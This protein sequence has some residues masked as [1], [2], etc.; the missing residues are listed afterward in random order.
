[1]L[2]TPYLLLFFF[3]S[4]YSIPALVAFLFISRET[5][6][7][8]INLRKQYLANGLHMSYSKRATHPVKLNRVLSV[9]R[10]MRLIGITSI[11]SPRR[12]TYCRRLGYDTGLRTLLIVSRVFLLPETPFFE[13]SRK[14]PIQ[15]GKAVGELP[16]HCRSGNHQQTN[17]Q[18]LQVALY[19]GSY[20]GL[21]S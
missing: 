3:F 2:R 15:N 11:F 17:R 9:N 6:K 18:Y 1:L 14:R 10:T 16:I 5:N 21:E 20:N 19:S 8:V 7:R 13:E 4:L 12:M